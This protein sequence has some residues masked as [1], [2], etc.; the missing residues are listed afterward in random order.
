LTELK[1]FEKAR[2]VNNTKA[3][4]L[5][6]AVLAQGAAVAAVAVAVSVVLWHVH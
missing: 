6:F 1:V 5:A 3:K 2:N 4:L